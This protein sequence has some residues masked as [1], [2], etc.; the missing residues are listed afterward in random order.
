MKLRNKQTKP[1]VSQQDAGTFV[2]VA[3]GASLSDWQVAMVKRAAHATVVAVNN[4]HE[5]FK[6]HPSLYVYAT[7]YP[8]IKDNARKVDDTAPF[9]RLTICPVAAAEFG[10]TLIQCADVHAAAAGLCRIPHTINCGGSSGYAAL[11]CA[12]N[13]GAERVIL[14][15]YDYGGAGHYFGLHPPHLQQ[16]SDWRAMLRPFPKLAEDAAALGVEVVNCSPGS[17]ITVFKSASL[18]DVL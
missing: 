10:W 11:H 14:L 9:A 16:A 3:T 7:D 17:A 1:V 5:L 4:A 6:G 8:W 13:A 12:I 2:C 15:G 18:E